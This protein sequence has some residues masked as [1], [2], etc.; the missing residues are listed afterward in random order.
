M[1]RAAVTLGALAAIVALPSLANGFVYDDVPIIVENSLVHQLGPLDAWRSS[2]WPAG[3]LYRP[4]TLQL[5]SLQWALGG[6]QPLLF[7][8]VSLLLAALTTILVY[9]LAARL[10]PE[11]GAIAAAAIFAVHPVHVEAV[12]S[13]VGQSEL[14]SAAFALLAVERYLAWREPGALTAGRRALLAGCTLLAIAAKETGYVVPLLLGAAELGFPRR[15]RRGVGGVFTLQAGAIVSALLVRVIA[16]G[17][18]AGETPSA[19]FYGLTTG[20]R[21]VGMLLVVPEWVRLMLWPVRLQAEYGPPGLPLDAPLGATHALG[22]AVLAAGVTLVGWNWRHHRS[23]AFAALWTAIAL[24]PVSNLLAAAGL[25]LAERTLFLPSIGVALLLGAAASAWW[26]ALPTMPGWLRVMTLT[27]AAALLVAAGLRSV[28]RQQAWRSEEAFF[29]QIAR[30]APRSYRAHLMA[31]R[32]YFAGH[33]YPEAEAAARMALTLYQNDP[34]VPE[35]LGQILRVQ[36]RCAE[37]LPVL[38]EGVSRFPDGTILRSRLIECALAV[39]DT[40]RAWAAAEDA[41][42]LG[43]P[44]FESTLKRLRRPALDPPQTR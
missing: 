17:S 22:L 37:A 12:A 34:R 11:A 30:D 33:R 25:V 3:G 4:L 42:A 1:K 23:V 16:L 24:A 6:G 10:L 7:H 40:G 28:V 5:F 36:G 29:G 20:Q 21:A 41:V 15:D 9:R 14:L 39:G 44:E 35:Q 32:Y 13:A 38:S 19:S 2:Y 43:Y 31:S 18:L 8:A 27:L 26:I